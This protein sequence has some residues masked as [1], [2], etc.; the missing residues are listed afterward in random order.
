MEKQQTGYKLCYINGTCSKSIWV[1]HN[2]IIVF[3]DYNL[4]VYNTCISGIFI[5]HGIWDMCYTSDIVR[6]KYVTVYQQ[7]IISSLFRL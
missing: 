4:T 2:A 6:Q 5:V 1:G 3:T 7:G